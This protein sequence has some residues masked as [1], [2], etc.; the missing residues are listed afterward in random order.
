MFN[1]GQIFDGSVINIMGIV[2]NFS[3]KHSLIQTVMK[4]GRGKAK[5]LSQNPLLRQPFLIPLNGE[6]S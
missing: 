2:I 5:R 1:N 6:Y 3:A 4:S